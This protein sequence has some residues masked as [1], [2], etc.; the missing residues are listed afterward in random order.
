MDT[1]STLKFCEYRK[2]TLDFLCIRFSFSILDLHKLNNQLRQY[3]EPF[4]D[5]VV[6]LRETLLDTKAPTGMNLFNIVPSPLPSGPQILGS[7]PDDDGG[8]FGFA[9]LEEAFDYIRRGKGLELPA[10]WRDNNLIPLSLPARI[11]FVQRSSP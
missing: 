3:P 9:R 11:P 7:M 5:A 2:G 4:A 10:H 1:I 8:L 6:R